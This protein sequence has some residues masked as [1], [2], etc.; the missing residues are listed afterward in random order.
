MKGTFS[1]PNLKVNRIV[2]NSFKNS[3]NSSDSNEEKRELGHGVITFNTHDDAK[4]DSEE[5]SSTDIDLTKALIKNTIQKSVAGSSKKFDYLNVNCEKELADDFNCTMDISSIINT[6]AR[7][8]K[9]VSAFGKIVCYKYKKF[10]PI[11]VNDKQLC[12]FSFNIPSPDDMI[13][14]YLKTER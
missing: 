4:I 10:V 12:K 6:T 7:I 1:I 2:D 11:I 3:V 5:S 9:R 13:L 14:K 8:S